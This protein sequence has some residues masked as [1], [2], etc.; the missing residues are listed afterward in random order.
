MRARVVRSD[1]RRRRSRVADG[2]A[3]HARYFRE[4]VLGLLEKLG[5]ANQDTDK[6]APQGS[7]LAQRLT[8]A[9]YRR[10]TAPAIFTGVKVLLAILLPLVV[11]LLP[12]P[13]L[14]QGPLV[15]GLMVYLVMSASACTGRN[16]G[17]T[18]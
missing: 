17:S 8:S 9:G 10:Q 11:W 15:K 13:A 7:A 14:D 16:C 3:G 6:A 4:L 18:R 2:R 5:R 12:I 1:G